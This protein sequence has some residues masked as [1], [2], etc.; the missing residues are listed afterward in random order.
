MSKLIK[1]A[2]VCLTFLVSVNANAGWGDNMG[3]HLWRG[4]RSAEGQGI[5]WEFLNNQ[6]IY[7]KITGYHDLNKRVKESICYK[8][9]YGPLLFEAP[10]DFCDDPDSSEKY[11]M[12][13]FSFDSSGLT[14]NYYYTLVNIKDYKQ[15]DLDGKILEIKMGSTVTRTPPKILRTMEKT[16]T[17][18][19]DGPILPR[20]NTKMICNG[21]SWEVLHQ[22]WGKDVPPELKAL[23]GTGAIKPVVAT[24]VSSPANPQ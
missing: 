18:K 24:E 2:L 1:S 13:A 5:A 19:D 3:D 21:W 12:L 16:D 11:F 14:W 6:I 10:K 17:C 7:A 20:A 22:Y 4:D 8:S 23:N 15:D 9:K